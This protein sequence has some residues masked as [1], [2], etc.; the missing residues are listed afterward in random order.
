MV[1]TT[2]AQ[3]MLYAL[4]IIFFFAFSH[5]IKSHFILGSVPTTHKTFI[6]FFV[7]AFCKALVLFF[8][9]RWC[10]FNVSNC[11][12]YYLIQSYSSASANLIHIFNVTIIDFKCA[13]NLIS[14]WERWNKPK[15]S[16]I[17]QCMLT[18]I[19][20]SLDSCLLLMLKVK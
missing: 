11:L 18:F 15:A 13:L 17:D 3:G 8:Y 1:H 7:H 9:C 14:R 19:Y 4:E 10:S 6:S 2:N 20:K 16:A 5:S 12:L